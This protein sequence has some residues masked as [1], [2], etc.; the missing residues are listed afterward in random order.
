MQVSAMAPGCGQ[1]EKPVPELE[2]NWRRTCALTSSFQ[3]YGE[4]EY[5]LRE[6]LSLSGCLSVHEIFK[7]KLQQVADAVDADVCR[8][9]TCQDFRVMGVMALLGKHSCHFVSPDLLHFVQD[10]QLIVYQHIMAGRE[11]LFHII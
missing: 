1:R 5:G 2:G 6:L 8:G 10:A 11:A 3:E 9:Q 7:P 4:F